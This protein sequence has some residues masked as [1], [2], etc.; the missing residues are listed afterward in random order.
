MIEKKC[1]E[2][3]C[4]MK[5]THACSHQFCGT[6]YYC[7]EHAK[8]DPDWDKDGGSYFFWYVLE[9]EQELKEG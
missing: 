9:G 4:S 8:A 6:I 3:G 5:A 7:E 2:C 1:M